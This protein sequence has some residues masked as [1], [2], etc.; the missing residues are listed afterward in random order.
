MLLEVCLG[1]E[2]DIPD[3]TTKP[4]IAGAQKLK[5]TNMFKPIN[6]FGLKCFLCITSII[7]E[8]LFK[9]YVFGKN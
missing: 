6:F 1:A 4:T 9:R 8:Q 7:N 5:N 3:S 2:E